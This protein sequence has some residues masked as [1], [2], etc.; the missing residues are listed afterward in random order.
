MHQKF[1]LPTDWAKVCARAQKYYLNFISSCPTLLL[2]LLS[3]LRFL[4]LQHMIHPSSGSATTTAKVWRRGQSIVHYDFW[5]WCGIKNK[6]EIYHHANPV[7]STWVLLVLLKGFKNYHW[8]S[9]TSKLPLNYYCI[10]FLFNWPI[11]IPAIT[12]SCAYYTR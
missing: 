5:N 3:L 12:D 2:T 4:T 6:P 10:T 1:D 11:Y 7:Y 8:N 9:D